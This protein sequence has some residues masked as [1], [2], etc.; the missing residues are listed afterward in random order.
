MLII[1]TLL[2]NKISS[3]PAPIYALR[4]G[5]TCRIHHQ[6]SITTIKFVLCRWRHRGGHERHQPYTTPHTAYPPTAPAHTPETPKFL[7]E[8]TYDPTIHS[9]RAHLNWSI[10]TPALRVPQPVSQSHYVLN[11]HIWWC[12]LINCLLKGGRSPDQILHPCNDISIQT[13][14]ARLEYV[15]TRVEHLSDSRQLYT[16]VSENKK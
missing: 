12:D 15:I 2:I 14:L 10:R 8:N 1:D 11:P 7:T 6:K 5:P 4:F 3:L 13:L 9:E 16:P